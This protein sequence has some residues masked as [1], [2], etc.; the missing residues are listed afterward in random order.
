MGQLIWV[1]F[2]FSTSTS[3]SAPY[4][5]VEEI[6]F[7]ELVLQEGKVNEILTYPQKGS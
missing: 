2:Y 5:N 7:D 4:S 6:M 3:T 1:G